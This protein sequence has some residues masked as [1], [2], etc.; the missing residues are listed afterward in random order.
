M[1]GI[2]PS[3]CIGAYL[4]SAAMCEMCEKFYAARVWLIYLPTYSHMTGKER[5][6]EWKGYQENFVSL[7]FNYEFIHL[8]AINSYK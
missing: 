8:L 6:V 2:V 4:L 7:P 3:K 1:E 5:L